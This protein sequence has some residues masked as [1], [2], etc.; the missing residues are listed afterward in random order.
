MSQS[1]KQNHITAPTVYSSTHHRSLWRNRD[2][3]I[4]WSGQLVS[5]FGS[6]IAVFAVPLFIVAFT[7]SPALAGLLSALS[8]VPSVVLS[9]PAGALVDRWNRKW[10]MIV[11]DSGRAIALVSIPLAAALGHLT[12]FHL[13]LAILL[14]G[15]L[16]PFF[17]VAQLASLPRIVEKEQLSQAVAQNQVLLAVSQLLG[18]AFGG[19]CYGLSQ[20]FPFVADGVSYVLSVFSLCFIK[21]PL[22]DQSHAPHQNLKAEIM[23][24]LTWL[25]RHPILRSLTLLHWALLAPTAGWV[26]LYEQLALH[27]HVTTQITGLIIACCGLGNVIGSLLTGPILKR[28][29]LGRVLFV[30]IWLWVLSWL[31][32]AIVPNAL[33]FGIVNVSTFV[34]ASIYLVVQSSYQLSLIPDHLQ[35][36]VNS[37]AR[38]LITGSQP[39]GIALTG[40]LIQ[41]VG[42][43][44]TA[45][46]FFIPQLL[47][48]VIVT[49]FSR[50]L[51]ILTTEN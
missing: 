13:A 34:I 4:L 33:W 30:V 17:A 18:P 25:W 42:P 48:A 37:I 27:L 51:F 28:F 29:R 39:L 36:R 23:E 14:E 40:V 20:T 45:L 15:T 46:A 41:F 21:K 16:T 8:T 11:C 26:L 24:G 12:I 22:Q 50:R 19:L 47:L 7:G 9:L 5:A 6:R 31:P 43:V 10:V 2:Y 49:L 3:V 35:G 38:L 44:A 1:Q 32:L